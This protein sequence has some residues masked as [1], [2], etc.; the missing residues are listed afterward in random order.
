MVLGKVTGFLLAEITMQF[1]ESKWVVI[2]IHIDT[3]GIYIIII[4][5]NIKCLKYL[6]KHGMF[7]LFVHIQI[8]IANKEGKMPPGNILFVSKNKS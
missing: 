3:Y 6:W 8:F 1:S 2:Y 7:I 4:I 5:S